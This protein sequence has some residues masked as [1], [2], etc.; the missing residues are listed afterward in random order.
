MTHTVET[1]AGVRTGACMGL[2]SKPT[3]RFQFAGDYLGGLLRVCS[4]DCGYAP[5]LNS[6]GW[7]V[8]DGE[9]SSVCACA[10]AEAS[11]PFFAVALVTH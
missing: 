8:G 3:G 7:Y 1:V 6:C 9:T 5:N 2:Q 11:N 4:Y 10:Q